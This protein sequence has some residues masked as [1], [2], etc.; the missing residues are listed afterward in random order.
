MSSTVTGT[1]P[2]ACCCAWVLCI[3]FLVAGGARAAVDAAPVVVE[4][5][6]TYGED[7][8]QLLDAGWRWH[9][10]DD[11]RYAEP[12]YDD[13]GWEAATSWEPPRAESDAT[14]GWLRLRFQ[15]A[16]PLQGRVL[17]LLVTQ[18][19]ASEVYLNGKRVAAFGVV[20]KTAREETPDFADRLSRRYIAASTA[21]GADQLL[22]IRHS[23]ASGQVL[24]HAALGVVRGVAVQA[25]AGSPDAA[26]TAF[27][28]LVHTLAVHQTFQV[29]AAFAFAFLH[30]LLFAFHRELRENLY[31]AWFAAGYGLAVGLSIPAYGWP[32]TPAGA[33]AIARVSRSAI[34][35]AGLAGCHFLYRLFGNHETR[36]ARVVLGYGALTAACAWALPQGLVSILVLVLIVEMLRLSVVAVTR[37][38][39][40]VWIV[41]AGALAF[42]TSAI[43]TAHPVFRERT[44]MSLAVLD[45]G[46]VALMG[47]MSVYLAQGFARTH[48]SLAARTVELEELNVQLEERVVERTA[49]LASANTD[50]EVR[51]QFIQRVFGR[52]LSEDIVDTLLASPEALQVGGEKRSI[53]ILMSDIRGFSPMSE[54]LQPEQVVTLLNNYL[55]KMT[56]VIVAHDGTIDEFIGDAILV[57]FGAPI[58][59]ED[60]CERAVACAV[61]M[62]GAMDEVNA[63]NVANGL[64]EIE[65]GI[66][67]NAGDVV[68]GNIGSLKRAKY[69]AV[70]AQVNLAARIQSHAAGGEILVTKS[71]LPSVEGRARV[72]GEQSVT[73]KGIRD[74]ATVHRVERTP[75]S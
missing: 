43:V 10:G 20:G 27:T 34:M 32:D 51:N 6:A 1:A 50:L 75:S 58:L 33:L 16:E 31:F 7:G 5:T 48:R 63:W 61:E 35:F 23:N 13:S 4:P 73:L 74:A 15:V 37:R 11:P 26:V 8:G 70:G 38:R 68:V 14:V 18:C 36:W 64:P 9:A 45:A 66:A 65:M 53:T 57:F 60:D 25:F 3:A 71:V 29:V 39:G 59:R 17:S 62:Q 52:Y 49:E 12:D 56:D 24:R 46:L 44:P 54:R 42:A 67:I 41:G 21:P 40:R 2:A 22:A 19:G 55:G 28:G 69:A 47:S 30:L 72:V